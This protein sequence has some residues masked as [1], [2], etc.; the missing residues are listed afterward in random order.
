MNFPDSEN[1]S[2]QIL[3][4]NTVFHDGKTYFIHHKYDNYAA[5]KMD[6]LLIVRDWFQ[7]KGD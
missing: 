7:E 6:I 3:A 1:S 2:T 4:T 5:S